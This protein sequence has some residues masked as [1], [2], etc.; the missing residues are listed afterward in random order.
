LNTPAL[1]PANHCAS[2][3]RASPEIFLQL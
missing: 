2:L 1:A 3:F